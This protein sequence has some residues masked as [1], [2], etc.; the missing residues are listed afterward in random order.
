M[1]STTP[2]EPALTT[3][4]PMTTGMGVTMSVDLG[5]FMLVWISIFIAYLV[6]FILG[7]RWES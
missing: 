1:R 6:G 2:V 4:P 5:T 7:K 3:P